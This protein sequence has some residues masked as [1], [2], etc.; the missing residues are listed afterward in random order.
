MDKNLAEKQPPTAEDIQMKNKVSYA[1]GIL[2]SAY[3]G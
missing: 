2:F 3:T 1:S